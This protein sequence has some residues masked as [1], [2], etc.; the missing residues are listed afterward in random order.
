MSPLAV[1][2]ALFLLVFYG[3]V[4]VIPFGT[5]IWLSFQN[6]D[7]I[8]DPTYVGARNYERALRDPYFWQA[9]RLTILFSVVEIAAGISLAVAVAVLLS[10]LFGRMQRAFL[11]LIYLPVITPTVV[12]VLL[13]R[14]LYL[15]NG[16]AFNGI[17][18]GLG[19]AEQPFLNSPE[20]ALWC[21]TV[22]VIWHYLGSGVILFLAGINDIPQHLF[23]AAMLDGASFRQQAWHVILPLLR[24][25]LYYQIVVSVIGTVQLFDPFFLMPGPGFST[26]TLSVYTYTLGFQT[27]NLGYGAAV[28]III[29]LMLLGATIVQLRYYRISWRY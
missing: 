22:M 23:E 15:P 14:W 26:R 7:Y 29:F 6:W 18:S 2:T 27:L 1:A 20:Q 12:S 17:L 24:P 8:V 11:G 16:G 10:R 21:V 4:F 3:V 28:S 25:V 19:L 13:W 5:S 9:L